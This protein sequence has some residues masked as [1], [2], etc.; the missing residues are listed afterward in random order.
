[1]RPLFN[2]RLVSA[3]LG[4]AGV[5]MALPVST[6]NHPCQRLYNN[7]RKAKLVRDKPG[8]KPNAFSEFLAK[9]LP[10]LLNSNT[11]TT[12]TPRT[13]W[14]QKR[15]QPIR[16]IPKAIEGKSGWSAI[17]NNAALIQTCHLFEKIARSS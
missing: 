11:P 5:L 10:T 12:T 6:I 9:L 16:L 15:I 13:V 2:N 3:L 1:M 7:K 17:K 8:P 14:T 4:R